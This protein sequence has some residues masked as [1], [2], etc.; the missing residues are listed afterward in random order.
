MLH[1]YADQ[2]LITISYIST[3]IDKRLRKIPRGQTRRIVSLDENYWQAKFD[4]VAMATNCWLAKA[5]SELYSFLHHLGYI[6]GPFETTAYSSAESRYLLRMKPFRHIKEPACPDYQ[7]FLDMV[8]IR[9]AEGDDE[10]TLEVLESDSKTQ[11]LGILAIVIDATNKVKK[12]LPQ[13]GKSELITEVAHKDE[14]KMQLKTAIQ[15]SVTAADCMAALRKCGSSVLL[16][17]VFEVE[18]PTPEE[19]YHPWWIVPRIKVRAGFK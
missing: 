17:E 13:F 2:A 8:T 1:Y 14:I 3:L 5:L 11:A 10:T 18:I 19:A 12:S 4:A 15:I 16:R 9:P 7:R 6:R